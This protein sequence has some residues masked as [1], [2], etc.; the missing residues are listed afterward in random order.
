MRDP[1]IDGLKVDWVAIG[2]LPHRT[3]PDRPPYVGFAFIEIESCQR[4]VSLLNG[5][6]EVGEVLSHVDHGVG[7]RRGHDRIEACDVVPSAAVQA[8]NHSTAQQRAKG[9]QQ[10]RTKNSHTVQL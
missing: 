4:P 6:P 8:E 2:I 1:I 9:H 5:E 10:E 3:D 7:L